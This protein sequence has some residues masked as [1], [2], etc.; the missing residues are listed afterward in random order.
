MKPDKIYHILVIIQ[1]LY[2]KNT[3]SI[4]VNAN[5]THFACSVERV[6]TYPFFSFSFCFDIEELPIFHLHRDG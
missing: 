1:Q 6:K 4:R 2:R 3:F 5:L